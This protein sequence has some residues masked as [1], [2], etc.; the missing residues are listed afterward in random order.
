MRRP[1]RHDQAWR[2]NDHEIDVQAGSPRYRN[3]LVEQEDERGSKTESQLCSKMNFQIFSFYSL[4]V[5]M[6]EKMR[7][8]DMNATLHVV[9][10]DMNFPLLL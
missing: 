10:R 5:D 9:R 6:D 4:V 3:I 1:Q 2:D 7:K 8:L